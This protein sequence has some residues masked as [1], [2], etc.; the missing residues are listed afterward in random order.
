MQ[1]SVIG[2]GA[3][4]TALAQV[5][6]GNGHQV[7]MWV[8]EPE[9]A[10]SLN[11]KHENEEFLPGVSLSE[12]IS[13]TNDLEKALSGSEMV[14]SVSPSHVVR[15][16]MS[17]ASPYIPKDAIMVSASKGIEKDSLLTMTGVIQEVVPAE[18]SRNIVALSGPSFAK[19]VAAGVPTALAAASYD[20]RVAEQVQYA[21][22]NETFRVYSQTD[23]MGVELGGAVKNPVAIAVGIADGM[24]LG[25]NTRAA[26]ITRGLAEIA[27]LGVRMGANPMT[28][29][30]LAGLGDLVLTCTGDLSR[31]RQVGLKIGQGMTL[32][33]ILDKT[34]SVAEGVKN[35]VT[36]YKL[37]QKMEV[38]M[39][40]IE[41]IHLVLYAE[42]SP[43]MAV[44][45]LM[46]RK[47][48][49]EIGL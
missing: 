48:K 33:E 27:R 46:T 5:C 21:L 7:I 3:W 15:Q 11:E 25:L 23:V 16:V 42:K 24:G 1:V 19:E 40:I 32:N 4:G 9:V 43:K 44:R 10:A 14:I 12:S 8:Y 2:G 31:N 6:A 34:R 45:D 29:A 39:P 17:E 20:I 26:I 30:G 36:V 47:L 35:A 13:A 18:V 37:S 22:S 41:Q 28:F 38:T 49:S